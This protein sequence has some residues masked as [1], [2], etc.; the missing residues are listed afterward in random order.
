MSEHLSNGQFARKEVTEGVRV[1]KTRKNRDQ[2]G[3]GKPGPGR[4]PGMP[5]KITREVK[6]FLGLLVNKVSVQEAVE[7][8]IE[9]GDAVAFFR[10]LEHVIGKPKENAGEP[11]KL[12][13]V[14]RW[15]GEK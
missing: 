9:A 12:E 5:N 14:F 6:E 4:P 15:E 2:I 3:G 11:I 1:K 7:A 13:A 8:R 10:A